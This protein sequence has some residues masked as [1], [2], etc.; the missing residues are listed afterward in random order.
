MENNLNIN[1]F[2]F[3][4]MFNNSK[5]K[6]SPGLVGGLLMIVV[7]CLGFM[8]SVYFKYNDVIM[9]SGAFAVTG[10]TLLGIRRFTDDKK[11]ET[12]QE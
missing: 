10:A 1:K 5:G 12:P 2:S 6:T 3:V 9:G 4:Q 8:W 11:L 7:A